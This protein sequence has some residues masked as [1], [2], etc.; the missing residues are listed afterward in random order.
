MLAHFI[1]AFR[2]GPPGLAGSE[3]DR[4]A[5]FRAALAQYEELMHAA[6]ETGHS[7]RPLPLFYALS[8]AGRAILAAWHPDTAVVSARRD[9]HGLSVDVPDD[10][11]LLKAV[12]RS[13]T[14]Q[15]KGHFQRVV[16]A[17]QL[18]DISWQVELGA[19]LA[20]LVEVV[21]YWGEDTWPTAV[22]VARYLGGGM[23][24]RLMNSAGILDLALINEE[25]GSPQDF[26]ELVSHYPQLAPYQPTLSDVQGVPMILTVVTPVGRGTLMRLRTG[27]EPR[28][29][30]LDRIAPQYRW[31]GRRWLVPSLDGTSAPPH[32]LLTWWA[33]LVALSSLARYQPVAWTR[34]LDPDTS[35]L[36]VQLE[37]VLDEALAALPQLVLDALMSQ[38]KQPV[39]L[40]PGHDTPPVGR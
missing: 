9:F 36:A 12:V 17:L 28:D 10:T 29:E 1:R 40:P 13:P 35:Q 19:L 31:L 25:I 8:Q 27:S 37:R 16:E 20:S 38:C 23:A 5:L 30:V 33:V 21:D 32:P 15:A 2:A 6:E 18:T 14:N 34:A 24:D 7:A 22:G 11:D 4:A 39:L 26:C 3:A